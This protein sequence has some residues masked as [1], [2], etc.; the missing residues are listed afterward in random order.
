[1]SGGTIYGSNA[2][3]E[4]ANIAETNGA[5]VYVS[6]GTANYGDSYGNNAITTTNNTI[7][8]TP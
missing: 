6:G 2:E 7:P 1:M 5:A 8:P 3:E 4:K